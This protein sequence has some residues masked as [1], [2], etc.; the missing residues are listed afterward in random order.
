MIYDTIENFKIYPG[1][2][3]VTKSLE[4]LASTDFS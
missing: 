4:F 3:G 2:G 1:L